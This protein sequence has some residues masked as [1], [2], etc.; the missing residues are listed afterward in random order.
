M[1]G[2]IEREDEMNQQREKKCIIFI[3]GKYLS[4]GCDLA[5]QL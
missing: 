1:F 4:G 3:V 2:Q 5:V